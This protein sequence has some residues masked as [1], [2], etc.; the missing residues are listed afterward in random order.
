MRV[1]HELVVGTLMQLAMMYDPT[2]QEI[3]I[4]LVVN[5]E[6]RLE[7]LTKVYCGRYVAAVCA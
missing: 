6:W 1:R 7:C 2:K 4:A 5:A 3:Q